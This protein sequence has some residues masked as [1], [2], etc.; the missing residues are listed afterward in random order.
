MFYIEILQIPTLCLDDSFAHSWHY[1]NQ[2]HLEYFS[3]SL[4]GVP[5]YAEHLLAT[6]PS[7]RSPTH[8]KPFKFG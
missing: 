7:L 8:P 5:T 1:L 4:E 2:F 3:N 6:F